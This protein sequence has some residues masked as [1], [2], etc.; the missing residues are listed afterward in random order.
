MT[1]NKQTKAIVGENVKRLREASN[2]S[3]TD[4]AK[5]IG[6]DRTY[7]YLLENGTV[8]FTIEKL[9]SVAGLFKV[10][11]EKLITSRKRA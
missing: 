6:V 1:I 7:W 11:M 2:R 5:E 10:P 3:V 9:E 8:N 4:L